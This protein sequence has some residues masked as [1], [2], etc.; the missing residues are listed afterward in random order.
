VEA[1][2]HNMLVMSGFVLILAGLLLVPAAA[3]AGI[4]LVLEPASGWWAAGPAAAV[5]LAITALEAG[6]VL[7]RLGRVFEATDPS[8]V[9]A[10]ESL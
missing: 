9:P 2:G 7:S 8:S 5:A 1:L 4:F 10:A 6:L 3:A